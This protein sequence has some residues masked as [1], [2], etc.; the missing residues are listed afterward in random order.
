MTDSNVRDQLAEKHRR[1]KAD[2]IA[3]IK[4][5]VA[6]IEAEPPEKWGPQ[7]NSL[8]NAQLES[9]QAAGLSAEHR[10]HV[11]QAATELHQART[12][13]NNASR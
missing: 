4:H 10:K 11:E 2:R 1:N 8:V 3:A 6:Y 13:S 5:W 7:L 12:D 9:A